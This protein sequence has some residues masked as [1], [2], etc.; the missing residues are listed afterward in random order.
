MPKRVI[1]GDALWGS[2]K[3]FQVQP[4][5]YRAEYANL[6]PLALA[7]GS[8]EADPRLIWKT[9]YAYNRPDITPEVV[10]EILAEFERVGILFRWRDERG[11]VWGFWI[12]IDKPGR[13][14]GESRR[15]KNERVG[16]PPPM[17]SIRKFLDSIC[18][19]VET[20]PLG[21]EPVTTP[22]IPVIPTPSNGCDL[23]P[24]GNDLLPDGSKKLLG[25]G[26]GLGK[27][28]GSGVQNPPSFPNKNPEPED[29]DFDGSIAFQQFCEAYPPKKVE[30]GRYVQGEFI[31]HAIPDVR[32]LRS[33]TSEEAAA[34]LVAK[35]RAYRSE[36]MPVGMQRW[37]EKAMYTQS[38]PGPMRMRSAAEQRRD[39]A[40]RAGE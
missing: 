34:F 11:V 3:L 10:G 20:T 35:A 12:N 23:L 33:C 40:R 16:A 9:V 2:G 24:S 5:E 15:G 28:L 27:G 31:E 17:D 19:Q 29:P 14:P 18:I 30:P 38:Q 26:S 13:L 4:L 39:R 32:K 1:D 22:D 36:E 25:F 37:L 8:F 21:A 7:N 6:I